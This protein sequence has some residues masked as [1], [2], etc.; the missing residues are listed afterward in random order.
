MIGVSEMDQGRDVRLAE[1][2]SFEALLAPH[3]VAQFFAEFWGKKPL[4]LAR[5]QPSFYAGLLQ[6]EGLE[7]YLALDEFFVRHSITT[8]RQGYGLPDPPPASLSDVQARL[9]AGSSLR[10]RRM[11]CFLHPSEPVMQLMRSMQLTLEHPKD[12]LSCY[13][14]PPGAEGLGAHHDETEIFTL[15]IAGRKRWRL[16]HRA[17]GAE[18]RVHD[19]STLAAPSADFVLEPGDLLYLPRNVVHEVTSDE[20]AFS[21]TMVLRPFDWNALLE[22]LA[23]KVAATR[24]FLTPLPA[25]TVLSGDVAPLERAFA[26]RIELLRGALAELSPQALLSAC[27]EKLV[28]G[29]TPEPQPRIAQLFAPSELGHDTLLERMP[30]AACH[31]SRRGERVVLRLAGGHSLEASHRAAPALEHALGA[32]AP[33]SVQQMHE[34]LSSTAKLA[35]AERLVGAGLLRIVSSSGVE[36]QQE[37]A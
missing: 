14:T 23:Q 22:L 10:L 6:L 20:P 15:Q 7:R 11:E 19:P 1:P 12:S 13:I 31:L 29:L 32:R 34:S 2:W 36:R 18:A 35:L 21:L 33:F 26:E 17:E 37:S 5:K 3:D 4:H 8:P 25:G 24:A 30:G 28:G 16:Y 9:V 27:A